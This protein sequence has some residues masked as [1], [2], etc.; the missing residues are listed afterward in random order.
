MAGVAAVTHSSGVV[1]ATSVGAGGTGFLAGTLGTLGATALS[2]MSAPAVIA[3][4]AG[5]AII[6]GSIAA[7]C[8]VADQK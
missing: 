8:Y 3:G 6:G 1:I 5:V 2:I 7:Y 4:A